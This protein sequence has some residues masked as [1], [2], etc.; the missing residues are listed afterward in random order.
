MFRNALVLVVLAGWLGPLAVTVSR[1]DPC[2]CPEGM[3]GACGR[4][5]AGSCSIR[6]CAPD[7]PSALV[8]AKVVLAT[9]P[10]LPT[11]VEWETLDSDPMRLPADWLRDPSVP[12]PRA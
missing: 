6:R 7:D 4:A 10:T 1:P 2:C 12:P 5:S 11:P 8:V 9:S 3:H